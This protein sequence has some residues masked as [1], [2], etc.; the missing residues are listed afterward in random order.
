MWF[1]ASYARTVASTDTSAP[2]TE[3]VAVAVRSDAVRP[4]GS[5]E[6]FFRT[7]VTK[8]P[9]LW[10]FS[11]CGATTVSPV[12]LQGPACVAAIPPTLTPRMASATAASL[13]DI[14]YIVS[15]PE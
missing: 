10:R 4:L 3:M 1:D 15:S 5:S 12:P 9:W 8:F 2:F 6:A 7:A 13:M 14:G 11:L